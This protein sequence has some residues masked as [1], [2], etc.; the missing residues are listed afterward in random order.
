MSRSRGPA[1]DPA[2]LFPWKPARGRA[3][4]VWAASLAT[5]GVHASFFYV[6]QTGPGAPSSQIPPAH[7]ITLIDRSDPAGQSFLRA[8]DDYTAAY[9][10][11]L[12]LPPVDIG[13]L[14][15]TAGALEFRPAAAGSR[16]P[17][18]PYVEP[19]NPPLLQP[20]HT[21]RDPVLPPPPPGDSEPAPP[22]VLDRSFPRLRVSGELSGRRIVDRPVRDRPGNPLELTPPATFRAAIDRNGRVLFAFP[23]EGAGSGFAPDVQAIRF[24]PDAEGSEL[25]WGWIHLSW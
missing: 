3:R 9:A 4:L 15:E 11:T 2:F 21:E 6:L 5:V 22:A 17:L 25:T 7:R 20:P 13:G 12:E 1:T 18:L 23:W 16:L 14:L 19:E 24:S 10:S 8:L